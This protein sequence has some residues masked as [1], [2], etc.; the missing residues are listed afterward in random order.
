MTVN[1][2]YTYLETIAP[3]KYQ[4]S[5]D[6]SGFLIGEGDAEV[7][8]ICLCLD[9]TPGIITEA[10]EKDANLIISHHP[11]IFKAVKNVMAGT[12][13]HKLIKH[14]INAICAHTNFD[15]AVMSD[16]MLALLEF[17]KSDEVIE[18]IAADGAG[19][20]K[21]VQVLPLT[22]DELANKCKTVFGSAFVKYTD[23]G[24]PLARI[25][26]CSG[27]GGDAIDFAAEKNCDALI[28]GEV[29]HSDMI[30]A[31]NIGLTLIEAGHYHT[32]IILCD[33]L[34][35]EIH[36]QFPQIPVFIAE[37]SRDICKYS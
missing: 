3:F 7:T 36:E 17:P 1:E 30:K 11:V 31:H 35:A 5:Y 28:T 12:P 20:G 33:F 13:V 26:V 27:S 32:E 21:V 23:A 15:V 29:K 9:I 24:K 16:I 34:K 22:A 19:F 6:N 18:I 14:D 25:G 37:N 2:I 10:H 4:E 8:G